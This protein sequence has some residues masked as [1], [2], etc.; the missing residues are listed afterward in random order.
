MNMKTDF[1]SLATRLITGVFGDVAQTVTIRR[2]IYSN[3]DEETGALVSAH[4]DYSVVGIL[5]PWKD[6]NQA[7]RNSDQIR[8]DDL[9]LLISKVTLEI[10]PEVN[11]DVAI[12]ADGTTWNII[13]SETD[14]AEASV[15]FRLT[16]EV[17]E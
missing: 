12:T 2:P 17:E 14:E 3:Y 4:E 15:K 5:G 7:A 11:V 1:Q 10:N 16:K 6:D 8:T 13:Y 9:S